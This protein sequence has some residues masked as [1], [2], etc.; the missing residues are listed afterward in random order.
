MFQ[1]SSSCICEASCNQSFTN[2]LK[3]ASSLSKQGEGV[4][5]EATVRL[6]Q[7]S[8]VRESNVFSTSGQQFSGHLTK[9]R[10]QNAASN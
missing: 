1:Y 5:D 9:R 8:E 3:A 10:S 7:R 4:V 2:V 6:P